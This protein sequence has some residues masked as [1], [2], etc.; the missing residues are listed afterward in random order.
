MTELE[1]Y[2]GS[3]FGVANDD[4]AKI[5]S[6]FKPLTLKK[7]DYFLKTGGQSNRLAFVQAGILREFVQVDDDAGHK[8]HQW[9]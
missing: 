1:K 5:S 6:F 2:I 8:H 9:L 3:Y 4:M 7:G